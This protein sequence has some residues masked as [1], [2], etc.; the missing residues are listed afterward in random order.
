MNN[1]Y[2][3]LMYMTDITWNV[4]ESSHNF[5]LTLWSFFLKLVL[6]ERRSKV[7]YYAPKKV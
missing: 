5:F 4:H 6:Y 3:H 1:G 2:E 7:E